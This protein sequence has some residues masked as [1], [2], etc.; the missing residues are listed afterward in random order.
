[1]SIF[2]EFGYPSKELVYLFNGDIVDR[3][4]KSLECILMIF[5]YKIALADSFFVT[6]GNHESRTVV[7]E[8]FYED[9]QSKLKDFES[10][11]NDFHDAF[12]TLPYGYVIK[13]EIFVTHGGLCADIYLSDIQNLFRNYFNCYN[14]PEFHSMLWNDPCELDVPVDDFGMASNPRGSGCKRFNTNVTKSFLQNNDLKLLVRSHQAVPEGFLLSQ[15]NCCVTVFSAPN[16][17]GRNI[18]GAVLIIEEKDAF[19]KQMRYFIS[20]N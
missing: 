16:Y 3:G 8:K 19:L 4:D 17:L 7:N 18:R 20:K 10:A 14:T 11:F 2:E 1:M 15:E 5:A 9:C 6:R 12:E 13:K